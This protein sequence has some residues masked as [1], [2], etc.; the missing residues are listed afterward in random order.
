MKIFN[1]VAQ[2]KLSKLKPDQFVE[3]KGYYDIGDGGGARYLVVDPQSFDGYGDHELANS[4]V[5]VVQSVDGV[6]NIRMFGAVG[7]GVTDDSLPFS[8]ALNVG[9]NITGTNGDIYY[10]LECYTSK[11]VNFDGQ[12]CTFKYKRAAGDSAPWLPPQR[13]YTWDDGGGSNTTGQET[14]IDIRHNGTWKNF[15]VDGNG[16]PYLDSAGYPNTMMSVFWIQDTNNTLFDNV[17]ISENSANGITAYNTENFK[18]LNGSVRDTHGLTGSVTNQEQI[19]VLS[20]VYS[21]IE[22]NYLGGYCPW[23]AINVQGGL[24]PL[25]T[26]NDIGTWYS[27]N[28]TENNSDPIVGKTVY[29]RVV[30]SSDGFHIISNNMVTSEP[31]TGEAFG[32]GIAGRN[33]TI[34]S[35][36]CVVKNNVCY[37]NAVTAQAGIGLG[38]EVI[39]T[40]GGYRPSIS[41]SRSEVFGNV[42]VGYT[43][44]NNGIGIGNFGS[45]DCNVHD[46]FI[47]NCTRGISH[48]RYSTCSV[49]DSNK[50]EF[51]ANGF[52]IGGLIV[53]ASANA[54]GIDK[55]VQITNSHFLENVKHIAYEDTSGWF[56]GV[57]SGNKFKD[58]T[59]SANQ[60]IYLRHGA[61]EFCDNHIITASQA[62]GI[63]TMYAEDTGSYLSFDNNKIFCI[64]SPSSDNTEVVKFDGTSTTPNGGRGRLSINGLIIDSPDNGSLFNRRMQI[65][66]TTFKGAII[67][68]INLKNIYIACADIGGDVIVSDGKID[69]QG[70]AS[71]GVILDA[72]IAPVKMLKVDNMIF[73]KVG[74][75]Y[76]V[77]MNVSASGGYG[78]IS[79]CLIMEDKN[80]NPDPSSGLRKIYN[81]FKVSVGALVSADT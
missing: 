4:N 54:H 13:E 16:I 39:S 17:H 53:S 67:S 34:N 37:N 20:S 71:I 68:N 1:N 9:G 51:C 49:Y 59:V 33:I 57:I 45:E 31:A 61:L 23:S 81:N 28:N 46:N 77:D 35:P 11:P 18:F 8:A 12:G 72:S 44:P 40:E 69:L 30:G 65:Q 19:T 80:I 74:A 7:D 58:T 6:A 55:R 47:Y 62:D 78:I 75:N 41:A 26:G 48:T 29:G 64:A 27:F 22:N 73:P 50:V 2:M 32:G 60:M 14:M 56:D 3:T 52:I 10:L 36:Q 24:L 5:A 15:A 42:I 79:N 38:H 70:T 76:P 43:D 25:G 63:I 66:R 21:I